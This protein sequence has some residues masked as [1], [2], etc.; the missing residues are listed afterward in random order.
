MIRSSV[1][2]CGRLV[3]SAAIAWTV[4]PVANADEP[5]PEAPAASS[6]EQPAEATAPETST[7]DASASSS[8]TS[9]ETPEKQ[10]HTIP[11]DGMGDTAWLSG[12]TRLVREITMKRQFEDLVICIGGCFGQ[13]DRVVYAQPAEIVS[14]KPVDTAY[15][16][17]PA[18]TPTPAAAM[19][20][21]AAPS[22]LNSNKSPA[23]PADLKPAITSAAQATAIDDSK[24][25]EFVPSTS[26][27]AP[28]A[29]PTTDAAPQPEAAKPDTSALQ[30]K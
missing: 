29:K 8:D 9:S 24:K 11:E 23:A 12:A 25:P 7:S 14:K 5:A 19:P 21:A 6:S 22:P 30:P 17:A 1:R 10:L 18:P 15:D 20:A 2:F 26:E 13:N 27:A 28:V 16:Q 3:L 4:I